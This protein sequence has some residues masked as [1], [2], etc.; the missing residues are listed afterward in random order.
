MNRFIIAFLILGFLSF[1]FQSSTVNAVSRVYQSMGESDSGAVLC[2]PSAL[3]IQLDDC[4]PLGPAQTI[5][6]LASQGIPYPSHPLPAYA[7][8]PD[9]NYLSFLYFKVTDTGSSTFATLE[10]AMAN[11]PS[12]YPIQGGKMLYVSYQDRVKN[13]QGVFYLLRSGIWINGEGARA[14]LPYPFQGLLFSSTPRNAFGWMLEEGQSLSAPGFNSPTTGNKYHRF[15]TL[16]VYSTRIVDNVEW[17]LIAPD[18][19][20]EARQVAR[21]D[22]SP[23]PPPGVNGGRWIEVNLYEQT[24][25]IYDDD[26]LVFATLIAS[27]VEPFWTRPG[28]FQVYEK[29]DS[30]TMSGSF[31]ADRSD[32]YY[33]EDVPWVMYFDEARALHGAYWPRL[34]GYPQSHGCVNLSIG[35]AHWLYAWVKTGDWVYVHDPSGKTPTDPSLYSAGAP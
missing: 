19:W 34:L 20:L 18:E 28:L 17:N 7:P 8:N 11:H 9:L 14:A 33:L 22:P 24:L 15:D 6:D 27:G 2:P 26:R 32:Y 16:Q 35:D 30:T 10:D 21:V 12:G 31:E 29:L 3:S 23:V 4:L 5:A 13:D 25:S 1:H